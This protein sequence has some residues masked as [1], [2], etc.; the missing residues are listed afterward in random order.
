MKNM[1][2]ILLLLIPACSTAQI[3]DEKD[4]IPAYTLKHTSFYNHTLADSFAHRGDSLNASA[5]FLNVSPYYYFFE[6]E[7]PTTIDTLFDKMLL[8]RDARTVYRERF[9]NVWQE[10]RSET[11]NMFQRMYQE[12]QKVRW[13]LDHCTDSL[14]YALTLQKMM[15]TDSARAD[16]LYSY[17]KLHNWPTLYNGAM[18]AQIIAVHDHSRYAYYIPVIKKAVT[19]GKASLSIYNLIMSYYAAAEKGWNKILNTPNKITIDV[20]SLI[21]FKMPDTQTLQQ[22]RM[23]SHTHCPIKYVVLI[24]ESDNIKDQQTWFRTYCE[25]SKASDEN[26]ATYVHD[27]IIEGSC[28]FNKDLTI[29]HQLR[30]GKLKRM[31]LNLVY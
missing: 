23:Q 30:R 20:S 19:E 24:Y 1:L 27:I 4:V 14:S 28:T 2:F 7:T 10:K 21:Q 31:M 8:T 9:L 17:V 3:F 25:K 5:A 13:K 6:E 11:Y 18:Y 12:D 16:T 15:H 22:I 29:L 26:A